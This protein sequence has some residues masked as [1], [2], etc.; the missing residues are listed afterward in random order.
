MLLLLDL[1][2]FTP[3]ILDK[4]DLLFGFF[5]FKDQN[6]VKRIIFKLILARLKNKFKVKVFKFLLNELNKKIKKN[7]IYIK[8]RLPNQRVHLNSKPERLYI[9]PLMTVNSY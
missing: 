8:N 5:V 4:I 6:I 3:H 9:V 2:F 7:I 1:L